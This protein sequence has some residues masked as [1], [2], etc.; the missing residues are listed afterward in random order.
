MI[1]RTKGDEIIIVCNSCFQSNKKEKAVVPAEAKNNGESSEKLG[2][3]S[4]RPQQQPP[5]SPTHSEAR[6]I[7]SKA[8]RGVKRCLKN[9]L[10]DKASTDSIGAKGGAGDTPNII[11]ALKT[12]TKTGQHPQEPSAKRTIAQLPETAKEEEGGPPSE[13]SAA[14]EK[15][16]LTQP[17]ADRS[18]PTRGSV[19]NRAETQGADQKPELDPDVGSIA[20]VR[21]AVRLAAILKTSASFN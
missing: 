14:N 8:E 9:K 11:N 4:D 2:L 3:S 13:K 16:P 1:A 5:S 7:S 20:Q 17:T 12:T 10:C 6:R 21:S 18:P 19:D 15:A